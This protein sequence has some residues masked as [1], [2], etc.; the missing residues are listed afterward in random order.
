VIDEISIRDLGV[1]SEATLPLGPGFTAITGETGAGKT[2]VVTALRLLLGSRADAAA[3]RSGRNAAWVEGRWNVPADGP[4]ADRVRDAGGQLDGPELILTRSVNAEGGSRG[5]IGGRSSPV[6]MLAELGES[7]VALHGQADQV[8]LRS[9]SAQRQALDRFA[10]ASMTA[11]LAQYS[12]AF[13]RWRA[14]TDQYEHIVA[15][16]ETRSREADELRMAVQDIDAVSP[17]EGEDVEL[18]ERA[19]RLSHLEELRFACQGA[20]QLLSGG[21]TDSVDVVSLLDSARKHI[22]SAAR[23][24]PALASVAGGIASAQFQ[25]AD[26]GAQLARYLADLDADGSGELERVQER[27]AAITNLVRRY[28]PTLDDVL[29]TLAAAGSRLQE[30]GAD[31]DRAVELETAAAEAKEEVEALASPSR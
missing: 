5:I 1:I 3:V 31:A 18:A 12:M 13:D 7:L 10:G 9:E 24:D 11:A 27:R 4:I 28:G 6:G 25:A 26:V 23:R 22:E 21:E 30:L 15:T 2:M 29:A 16:G 8:R 14:L 17:K 20:E 19:E